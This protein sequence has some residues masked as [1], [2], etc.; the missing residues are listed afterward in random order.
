[1]PD[2]VELWMVKESQANTIRGEISVAS[3]KDKLHDLEN[4]ETLAKLFTQNVINCVYLV[5]FKGNL[6]GK[7]SNWIDIYKERK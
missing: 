3:D 1:M 7:T 5:N 2:Q 4:E 6:I